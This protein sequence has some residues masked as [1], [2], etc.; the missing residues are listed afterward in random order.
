[1]AYITICV[2]YL[3]FHRALK[4]Q[5]YNR[6]GLPYYGYF[7]PYG[8]WVALVWLV[9]VEVF[10]GYAVFLP[11]RW[12]IKTFCSNYAMA[13]LAIGFFAGWKLI[14]RTRFVS[15]AEADLVW[16]RPA[17][18]RHEATMGE[19]DVGVHIQLMQMLRSRSKDGRSLTSWQV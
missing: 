7:Q 12:D 4:A 11:G 1:M 17:I 14:K 5:G 9:C 19:E 2:N 10:Y 3:F 15:P 8:T 6:A 16:A 18:D 13:L